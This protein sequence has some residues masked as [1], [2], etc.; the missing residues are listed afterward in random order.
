MR[1][2]LGPPAYAKLVQ[3]LAIIDEK[4]WDEVLLGQRER[5][6]PAGV[7]SDRS[8]TDRRPLGDHVYIDTVTGLIV[9]Q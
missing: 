2:L 4:R 5:T 7:R 1:I 6:G 8:P 3:L 9:D